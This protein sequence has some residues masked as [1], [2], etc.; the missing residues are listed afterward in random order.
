MIGMSKTAIELQALPDKKYNEIIVKG[1]N[2]TNDLRSNKLTNEK[3]A[4]YLI[5]RFYICPV[6]ET[7]QRG[8]ALYEEKVDGIVLR[9]F[10]FTCKHY[11]TSLAGLQVV[12]MEY[13]DMF[14]IWLRII[15]S[16]EIQLIQRSD[17]IIYP[18]MYWISSWNATSKTLNNNYFY[19]GSIITTGGSTAL[20]VTISPTLAAGS[21]NTNFGIVV[22]SGTNANTTTTHALQTPIANGTGAG[23]LQYGATGVSAPGVSGSIMTVIVNRALTNGSGGTVTITEVA[24]Y[25]DVFYSPTGGDNYF[26][27]TRDVLA[28]AISLANGASTTIYYTLQVTMS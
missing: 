21:G 20:S 2:F 4:Q 23:Q 13:K 19:F 5:D 14:V 16:T 8:W 11:V 3:I 10:F 22:G 26:A 6:C 17:S 1:Y 25:V 27:M 15:T 24:M 18:F 28:T 9:K 7:I 12:D